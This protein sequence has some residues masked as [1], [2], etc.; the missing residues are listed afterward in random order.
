MDCTPVDHHRP[1]VSYQKVG[2]SEVCVSAPWQ[3]YQINFSRDDIDIPVGMAARSNATASM[4][5][6]VFAIVLAGMGK[7]S[8]INTELCMHCILAPIPYLYSNQFPVW[9]VAR[10]HGVL[11]MHPFFQFAAPLEHLLDVVD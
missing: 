4:E 10:Y 2:I 7:Y 8:E 3:R 11:S 5:A 1:A 9:Q 6:I